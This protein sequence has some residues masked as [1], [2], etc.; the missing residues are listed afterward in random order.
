MILRNDADE[1]SLLALDE[2]HLLV[3]LC[4]AVFPSVPKSEL[5]SRST[6]L[7]ESPC[8]RFSQGSGSGG[9]GGVH[10]AILSLAARC[11]GTNEWSPKVRLQADFKNSRTSGFGFRA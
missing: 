1:I 3:Y 7:H 10:A 8:S 4:T 2:I 5:V 9:Y 6:L 11:V